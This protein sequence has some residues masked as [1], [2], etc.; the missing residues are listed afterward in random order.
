M[1]S[2]NQ[3]AKAG[4]SEPAKQK[5]SEMSTSGKAVHIGKIIIFV[6]SFGFAFPG[7]FS[8]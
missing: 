4:T 5:F 3:Q 1:A 2:Q 8:D 7:L 6:I